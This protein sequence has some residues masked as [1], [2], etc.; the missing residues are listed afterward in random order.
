[1]S[2]FT[3]PLFLIPL[4]HLDLGAD[5]KSWILLNSDFCYEV[6]YLGSG[7]LICVPTGFIT[8]LASVPRLLWPI[9]NPTG[10]RIS[11]GAVIHDFL[12]RSAEMRKKY[13]RRDADRIIRNA[14]KA[15]GGPSSRAFIVWAALRLFAWYAWYKG[16]KRDQKTLVLPLKEL[17]KL[18]QNPDGGLQLCNDNK[19]AEVV[20][21]LK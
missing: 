13:N 12:Y 18:E 5:D 14:I 1:M 7:E 11:R 17:P 9:V 21:Q 6:G 15:A 19:I 4:A 8:D 2:R 10:S 3:T 16:G 20:R